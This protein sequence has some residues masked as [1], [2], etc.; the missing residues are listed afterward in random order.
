MKM[1]KLCCINR[2]NPSLGRPFLSVLGVV[3][4]GSLY[5]RLWKETVNCW[6]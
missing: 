6:W 2:D 5:I 3:F 4:T 1:P